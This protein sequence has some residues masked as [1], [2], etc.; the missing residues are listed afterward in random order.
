MAKRIALSLV[1]FLVVS[2]SSAQT[3]VRVGLGYIPDVQFAP[4]Y[5][6]AVEGLYEAEG[7]EVSFQHGFTS[8]LYPLLEQGNLDFV[9]GDAEDIVMLRSQ[10]EIPFKYV[11]AMYQ[12]VPTVLFGLESAVDGLESLRGKTIGMPALSGSSYTSLQAVLAAADLSE[13]DVTIQEIGFT[14]VE[15]VLSER[16]DMAMGFVNNEPLILG[17]MGQEVSTLAAGEYNP[18]VGNGVITTDAL[19]ADNPELVRQFVQ[20][21]QRG[22]ALVLNEPEL[23]FEASKTYVENQG[24]ERLDVLLTSAELYVSDYT[25]ENGLGAFDPERFAATL[26]FLS[27]S[28]RVEGGLEPSVFYSTDFIDPDIN[29]E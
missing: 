23:A 15:A 17:N 13:E 20:A 26:E 21:S 7:L 24:D 11:M 28:E 22:L 18:S 25:R 19:I 8:E 14:Q 4:F 12:R 3:S 9:V 10:N 6:A 2:L 29:V 27:S 1:V 5:A 16:V